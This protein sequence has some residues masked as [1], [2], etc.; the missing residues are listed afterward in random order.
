[1][2]RALG[3]GPPLPP[4]ARWAP[5][6]CRCCCLCRC[7]CRCACRAER[8]SAPACSPPPSPTILALDARSEKIVVGRVEKI[9]KEMSLMDQAFIK[10][11]SKTVAVSCAGRG[12]AGLRR[13]G[14]GWARRRGWSGL[15]WAW[16]VALLGGWLPECVAGSAVECTCCRWPC[17][18][19]PHSA[20]RAAHPPCSHLHHR[21]ST[22]RSRLRASARTSRSA[23][24][25]AS[26]WARASRRRRSTLRPRWR[27]RPAASSEL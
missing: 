11:T 16:G 20:R 1:M 9:A 25:R 23:A 24:L 21:R 12:W 3:C 27:P 17:L 22:S 19:P 7:R 4:A 5:A 6:C 13:A 2:R 10:D 18:V 26:C 14:L 8:P 15:G